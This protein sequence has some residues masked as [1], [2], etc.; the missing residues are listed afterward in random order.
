[1]VIQLFR[2]RVPIKKTKSNQLNSYNITKVQR[3]REVGT[4]VQTNKKTKGI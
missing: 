3:N 1:M 2:I 4:I